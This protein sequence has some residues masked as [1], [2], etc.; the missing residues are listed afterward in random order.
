MESIGFIGLGAMGAPM[1][2]NIRN[3]GYALGVYNRT[4]AA[5]EPFRALGASVC[6]SPKQ[7]AGRADITVIMVTGPE[8]LEEVISGPDGVVA[9]LTAGKAVINMSTV[10]PEATEAA[11]KAVAEKGADF[12]DAPVSGSVKPAEEGT[13]TVLAGAKDKALSRVMPVLKSMAGEVIACGDIGQ[14]T[15]MKLV[16]NLMLGNMMHA[17]AEGMTLGRRFGLETGAILSALASGPMAAPMYQLKGKAIDE[18]NFASQFPV[19]LMAKDLN[20]LLAAA[21]ATHT[22]L[23]QTEAI[24]KS[25]AAAL[26]RGLG[27]QDMAAV[28]K[29]L[30]TPSAG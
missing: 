6:E 30:E 1:A 7:T 5:A 15:R 11:A 4:P 20:L 18:G 3:G 8:A 25:F 21:E 9:G 16:L 17:L 29:L 2:R 14:G 24:R 28:I 12:V 13:L 23:P 22:S 27:D 19:R 26:E 10:S